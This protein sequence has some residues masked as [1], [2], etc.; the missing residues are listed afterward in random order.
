MTTV[1]SKKDSLVFRKPQCSFSVSLL[2][3]RKKSCFLIKG[4]GAL[5]YK[6]IIL[7]FPALSDSRKEYGGC[8]FLSCSVFFFSNE[9]RRVLFF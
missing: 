8:F 3:K 6:C 7:A 9:E 5:K 2:E 4:G 1:T